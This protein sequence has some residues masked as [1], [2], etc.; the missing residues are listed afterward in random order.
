[1]SEAE[2]V[3]TTSEVVEELGSEVENVD[4]NVTSEE[5]DTLEKAEEIQLL[6]KLSLKIDGEELEEELPFDIDPKHAEWM[7]KQLQLARVSQKRMQ[8]AAESRKHTQSME[9]ELKDFILT[10]RENPKE[11]LNDPRLGL[12][13]KALAQQVMNEELEEAA[14]SP[15]QLAK[16][17]LELEREDLSKKLE[18]MQKE[19]LNAEQLK[20]ETELAR[21]YED[22]VIASMEENGLQKDPR[23]IKRYADAM[24]AG[25]KFNIELTPHE[26][27]PIIKKQMYE[28]AK[29]YA[30]QL[31]DE[32]LD[33]FLGKDRLSRVRKSMISKLRRK[34]PA[35]KAIKDTGI[36]ELSQED[37]VFAKKSNYK[38]SKDFF[39]QLKK[40][41]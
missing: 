15:E 37:N 6:R 39:K 33:N 35:K 11:I 31:N 5:L 34:V 2:S 17:K 14:K 9:D 18:Q 1:M 28:E 36:K 20:I 4:E 7:Q 19:K 22:G 30:T 12:D 29:F 25:L 26:I 8:E 16:E 13:L 40:S 21:Q 27:G 3:E 23:V 41:Y 10:L 24:R 38:K 32:E